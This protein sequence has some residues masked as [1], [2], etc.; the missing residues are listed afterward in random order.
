MTERILANAKLPLLFYFLFFTFY[1]HP[2]IFNSSYKSE[3]FTKSFWQFIQ[4]FILLKHT[5]KQYFAF[6]HLNSGIRGGGVGAA[7]PKHPLPL[8]LKEGYQPLFRTSFVR[9][10]DEAPHPPPPPRGLLCTPLHLETTLI[11]CT[12]IN[13]Q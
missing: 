5:Q 8:P 6:R 7:G 9:S 4:I 10:I 1:I 11:M 13:R 2:F 3:H 12:L